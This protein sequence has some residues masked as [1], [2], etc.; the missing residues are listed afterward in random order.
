MLNIYECLC[1]PFAEVCRLLVQEDKDTKYTV[2]VDP[3]EASQVL[4]IIEQYE[5]NPIAI[6]LTHGHLDHVGGVH[7]IVERYPNIKVYG[8]GIEDNVLI[9]ALDVQAEAFG[10]ESA[11]SFDF[12]AVTDDQVLQLFDD[13]SFKVLS[14]PG[15][16][17]GGVCYYCSEE[18]FVLVGDTLFAGSIGRT[19]FV[20]GSLPQILESIRTKLYTLPDDT[21]VFCGHGEDTKIGREKESNPYTRKR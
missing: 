21:D 1:T 19:D 16:T 5:L 11:P 15:H 12:A 3:G 9:E 17:R 7:A 10:I 2:I 13:A 4:A 20:G 14:T 8:P 6:L 18:N